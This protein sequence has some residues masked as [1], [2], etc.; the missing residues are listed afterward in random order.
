MN[1][2]WATARDRYALDQR[3]RDVDLRTWTFDADAPL[4]MAEILDVIDALEEIER[5]DGLDPRTGPG[6]VLMARVV[7]AV[8]GRVQAAARFSRCGTQPSACHKVAASAG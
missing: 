8:S 1:P 2:R 5:L 6:R 3:A 7:P 4:A